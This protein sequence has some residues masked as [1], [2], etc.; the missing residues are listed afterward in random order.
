M[1]DQMDTPD[2]QILKNILNQFNDSKDPEERMYV[3][4]ED[5]TYEISTKNFIILDDESWIFF[6]HFT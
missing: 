2:D 3:E 5:Q 6:L 4:V 1:Q